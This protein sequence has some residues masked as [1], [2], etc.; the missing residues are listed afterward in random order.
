MKSLSLKLFLLLTLSTLPLLGINEYSSH[1]V[2]K[3]A[4]QSNKQAYSTIN[5]SQILGR[6]SMTSLLTSYY[7]LNTAWID[8][9][10][11]N[12]SY[13][14]GLYVLGEISRS[15]SKR[16]FNNAIETYNETVE[17]EEDQLPL[18][19]FATGDD[20]NLA[21][22]FGAASGVYYLSGTPEALAAAS[23][24][25]AYVSLTDDSLK[26]TY[27]LYTIPVFLY[28]LSAPE[29]KRDEVLL[30]NIGIIGLEVLLY[31]HLNPKTDQSLTISSGINQS[32]LGISLTYKI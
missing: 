28:N 6:V 10:T 4:I 8:G 2:Y 21:L 17:N 26:K 22:L 29:D 30:M 18:R 14:A 23:V 27:A 5:K 25:G 13:A 7:F 1:D 11:E 12:Y 3:K 9:R 32:G 16:F 24:Y 19:L 20:G 31:K 15:L